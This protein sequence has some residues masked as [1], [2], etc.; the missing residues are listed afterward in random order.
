MLEQDLLAFFQ[1]KGEKAPGHEI[2][3]PIQGLL[4]LKVTV[5]K[6]KPKRINVL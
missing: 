1:W 3:S 4:D 5:K 2:P 6:V